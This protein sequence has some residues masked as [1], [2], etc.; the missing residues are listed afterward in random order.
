M[1]QT[2]SPLLLEHS[3]PLQSLL[4]V[5]TAGALIPAPGDPGSNFLL[6]FQDSPVPDIRYKLNYPVR[7]LSGLTLP[8]G[9]VSSRP[10]VMERAAVARLLELCGT[11]TPHFHYPCIH[12]GVPMWVVSPLWLL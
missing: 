3:I 5:L 7:G 9:T 12:T 4:P 10:D 2:L 1:L 6:Y 8:C 11:D